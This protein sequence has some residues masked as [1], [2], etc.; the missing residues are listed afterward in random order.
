MSKLAFLV[1]LFLF[2]AVPVF[3]FDWL[4]LHE[5]AAKLNPQDAKVLAD[6][7]P[8]SISNLYLSALIYLDDYQTDKAKS[9]FEE[10]VNLSPDNPFA[11]WGLLECRRREYQCQD[12]QSE[13]G[14]IINK[15]QDFAPAYI[16]LAYLYYK[17]MD[18]DKT[19]K[20]T[21]QVIRMG[22]EK[23]DSINYVRALGLFAG[24]KGMTAHYG[25][26]LSKLING[27]QVMPA[28]QRA[29]RINPE[30]VVVYFGLGSYY[31]LSPPL[32]GRDFDKAESY[33]K[34]AIEA[35]P[36]FADIYVRLAQVYQ[37]KGEKD[38]Y[39]KYL[40]KALELDP[41]NHL[42]LDIKEGICNFICV[43]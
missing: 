26:P 5:T 34:K 19:A 11:Q 33:L 2:G 43:D 24:A 29:K 15:N 25:G 35:D 7:K 12:C 38:K 17:D 37:V 41:Q 20:L 32:F 10:I 1:L 31:L 9:L 14:R 30:S 42:A 18:F 3:A 28:I 16:T 4:S 39:D 36:N 22:Q 6:E 13:L 21:Q 40:T 23:V 8:V 27:R